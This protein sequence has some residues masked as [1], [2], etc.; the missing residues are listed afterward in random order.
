[1]LKL[2]RTIGRSYDTDPEDVL[3]V[4]R[5]LSRMG[6]YRIPDYGLTP[7]ADRETFEAIERYQKL[8]GLIVDGV[9]KPGGETEQH[10]NENEAGESS[11]AQ[12][13]D[14]AMA[15]SPT[16]WCTICGA[17]HGGVFSPKICH[18]C[19]KKLT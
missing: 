18:N 15:K 1:M 17:P 7:Y 6:L 2:K 4:K 19:W 5:A 9:I 13:R 8:R 11:P 10:L 12:N 16:F 14:E 3:D